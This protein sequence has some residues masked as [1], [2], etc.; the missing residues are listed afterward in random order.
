M[1]VGLEN[2]MDKFKFPVSEKKYK[3]MN[4]YCGDMVSFV[5]YIFAYEEDDLKLVVTPNPEMMVEARTNPDFA[6]VLRAVDVRLID[7]YGLWLVLKYVYGFK[8]VS[9]LTG[10]D[11]MKAVLIRNAKESQKKKIFLLGAGEGVA[12]KVAE[13]YPD[14]EIV[15]CE[16]PKFSLDEMEAEVLCQKIVNSGADI[17]FVAFGAPKQEMWMWKFREKLEGLSFVFGVGGAFDFLA[18]EVDRAPEW[19]RKYG[20]EWLYRLKKQPLKRAKRIWT[21]V[22]IFPYGVMRDKWNDKKTA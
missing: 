6:T 3:G 1:Y 19:M 15:G 22:F 4:F 9:R 2:M 11:L 14:S 13:L 7:G 20:L 18:G 17:L 8:N 21:A 12:L 10:S 5:N 16:A